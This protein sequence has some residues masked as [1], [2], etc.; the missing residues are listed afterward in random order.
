MQ[1]LRGILVW[2]GRRRIAASLLTLTFGATLFAATAERAGAA[3]PGVQRETVYAFGGA[4][5]L[6]APMRSRLPIVGMRPTPSGN[7]YW[8]TAA[9]GG[10]FT[11]GDAHFHGSTGARRLPRPIVGMAATLSGHG[12]SLAAS[13]GGVF[14]FGDAQF[15]G[16]AAAKALPRPIAGIVRSSGSGYWLY[17][18]GSPAEIT[19]IIARALSP[20]GQLCDIEDRVGPQREVVVTIYY[21]VRLSDGRVLLRHVTRALD[22]HTPGEHLWNITISTDPDYAVSARPTY[23]GQVRVFVDGDA[24]GTDCLGYVDSRPPR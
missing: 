9:D 6:G 23:I 11:F 12:Y 21:T 7:G 4:P 10:I 2:F 20:D 16:S 22:A 8:L 1:L 17:A 15:H 19:R 3:V 18:G 14:T 5:F 13:N 24:I